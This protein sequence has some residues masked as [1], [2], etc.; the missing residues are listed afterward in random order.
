MTVEQYLALDEA[1]DAKYEY[2]NGYVFMLRPP[3]FAY[4]EH[5][6]L[7]MAGGSIAH[8]ALCLRMGS[9]LDQA[10]T[11]GPCMAFSSDARMQLTE[12]Q[13]YYPDITVACGKGPGTKLTNPIVVIEVLSPATE[14]RDH[15]AKFKAY[16]AL[17]SVQEYMLISSEYQAIE[18]HQREHNILY[19]VC[20]VHSLRHSYQ[21]N[22]SIKNVRL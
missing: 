6:I 3:S 18:V 10:L 12:R 22:L 20:N 2:D 19:K 15:G 16:K 11:D 5:A 17:P 14:K 4:D 9:L 21:S 7:D 1:T 13:Y 8:A